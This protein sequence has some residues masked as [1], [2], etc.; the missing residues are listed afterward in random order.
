MDELQV[1]SDR[2]TDGLGQFH[3][4]ALMA[5][6]KG[7]KF[8]LT[9]STEEKIAVAIVLNRAD[10]LKTEGYTL[11]EAFAAMEGDWSEVMLV[12][13]DRLQ[14]N[15]GRSADRLGITPR[16][17]TSRSLDQLDLFEECESEEC[18]DGQ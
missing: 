12:V 9:Q 1:A 7:R 14:R 8:W 4:K 16:K 15:L 3:S 11:A 10:W 6:V 18:N 17:S 13:V 5:A 2:K